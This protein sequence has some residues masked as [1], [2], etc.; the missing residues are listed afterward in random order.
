LRQIGVQND[1]LAANGPNE[2]F[3]RLPGN[4]GGLGFHAI[5]TG[6]ENANSCRKNDWA[7]E[8]A[9]CDLKPKAVPNPTQTMSTSM[10]W[11]SI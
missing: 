11:R 2:V 8:I 10:R 4:Y 1:A 6:S 7:F 3:D 9:I 5:V